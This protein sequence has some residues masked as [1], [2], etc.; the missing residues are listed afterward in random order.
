MLCDSSSVVRVHV[1]RGLFD[2]V[3]TTQSRPAWTI[4]ESLHAITSAGQGV[5]V[6]LAYNE[7]KNE[8]ISRLERL[9]SGQ[10]DASAPEQAAPAENT[11]RMLGAGG[12]ILADQ[13]VTNMVALGREKKAFGISGFGLEIEEYLPDIERFKAWQTRNKT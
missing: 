1:H 10:A 3:T 5:L 2:I 11:L 7:G 12:Q 6:L 8:L 9:D 4:D 13:G